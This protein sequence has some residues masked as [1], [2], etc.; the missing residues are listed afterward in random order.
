MADFTVEGGRKL[1]GEVSVQGAKNSALPIL[2]AAFCCCGAVRLENCP[3]LADVRY[4]LDILNSLGASAEYSRGGVS[5][6]PASA[7]LYTVGDELMRKM[8]SSVVFMGAMLAKTGKAVLT[9]PGGC[10]LGPRP[11]DLHLDA[12]KRLGAKVSAEGGKIVCSAENRL[13]GS[14][15]SL[16]FPSVGATENLMIAACA[17]KGKTVINNAAREPEIADLAGF[18]NAC[19]GKI[20]GAGSTAISVQGVKEL[21]GCEYR[22]MPDR[23][24]AATLMAATEICGG[25]IYIRQ[26]RRA[27]MEAV[28]SVLTDCGARIYTAA[29]G[30]FY[31]SAPRTQSIREL[32][33]MPYPG[34]PTDAQPLMGAVLATADGDS[35]ITE[36]IFEHRYA[37][38]QQLSRMGAD[39]RIYERT[40]VIEGKRRLQ[41][42][43]VEAVDLRGGAALTIAALGAQGQS[44]VHGIEPIERGYERLDL[45]LAALGAKI[46]RRN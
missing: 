10:G 37:Y 32:K 4:S 22:V 43:H 12:M 1:E 2:A 16:Q 5:V 46:D 41:G 33:T 7:P 45:T 30:I 39:I 6:K 24:A 23:I 20:E 21:G 17:A 38:A 31:K 14:E 44:V 18:L 8:R 35:A 25:E 13:V 27:D 36:N 19:G 3:D 26:A 28:L 40:A 29:G 42:A 11:I 9:Y 34:F 15:I